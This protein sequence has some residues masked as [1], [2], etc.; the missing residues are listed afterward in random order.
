MTAGSRLSAK[1]G[2][3]GVSTLFCNPSISASIS[4]LSVEFSGAL[5]EEDAT[6]GSLLFECKGLPRVATLLF[7][8][9]ISVSALRLR[10]GLRG[11][12]GRDSAFKGAGT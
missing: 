1:E 12:V 6:V 9:S 2:T 10:F 7:G 4:P 11:I 3:L 5:E 8:S